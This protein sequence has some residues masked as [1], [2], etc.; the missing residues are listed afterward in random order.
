MIRFRPPSR[1]VSARLPA[2]G[3]PLSA[4]VPGPATLVD[5]LPGELL[6]QVALYERGAPSRP[7]HILEAQPSE[8][9]VYR[10]GDAGQRLA[11][12]A[13]EPAD[14]PPG[15]LLR[16]GLPERLDQ[17]AQTSLVIMLG[18]GPE[19]PGPERRTCLSIASEVLRVGLE[20]SAPT[21][22]PGQH[23]DYMARDY[24]SFQRLIL[25]R[26]THSAPQWGERH[27]ADMGV[28][29]AEVLAY[30][31]DYLSYYQDAVATE[32]YLETARRRTSVRRHVRLL[33][34]PMHEGC[35]ARV[36]VQVTVNASPVE[37]PRGTPLL[38]SAD[39]T[40]ERVPTSAYQ[41]SATRWQH[42]FETMHDALLHEAHN[43]MA[44]YTWGAERY[45]LEPGSLQAALWGHLPLL[46]AG[47]VLVFEQVGALSDSPEQNIS[48]LN[49][50]AVRLSA[51]ALLDT[52]QAQHEPITRIRWDAADA[53]PGACL[54][55]GATAGGQVC[56][57][58]W[59]VRGNLVLADA[60]STLADEPLPAVPATGRFRP[61]LRQRQIVYATPYDHAA[62]C[63]VPA[64]HILLQDP[65][66]ALPAIRLI[67]EFP[68]EGARWQPQRDLGGCGRFE[69]VFVAE[70]ESDGSCQLR[71]GNG[72]QGRLPTST[73]RL[74]ATYRVDHGTEDSIGPDTLTRI[75]SDDG[76]IEAVR[77]LLPARGALAPE[78]LSQVRLCAPAIFAH[79]HS[80]VS[81]SDYAALVE[82]HPEV[83]RA[84]VRQG[85]SGARPLLRIWVDRAGRTPLDPPFQRELRAFLA[86]YRLLGQDI[87]IEPPVPVS[88]ELGLVVR[89]R[90]SVSRQ[91]TQLALRHAFGSARLPGGQTGFFHPD[92][93]SFGQPVYLSQIVERAL[94]VSGVADVQIQTFQR[95]GL[96]PGDA[97]QTGRLDV[98][99]LEIVRLENDPRAPQHGVLT[100]T[101]AGGL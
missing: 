94:R 29:L 93:F 41:P 27:A 69:R 10:L 62:A 100:L 44:I 77:N 79:Q 61:L 60:G 25:E 36:W 2:P 85:W 71:F 74:R 26:M 9:L 47:D 1:V 7:A 35:N 64:T 39:P 34:Y 37:L 42:T 67:E 5:L 43:R 33:D 22:E 59:V 53:L 6:V 96:P 99:E 98:G 66:Q 31:A 73:T 54:V 80:A 58:L 63:R 45:L 18:G 87:V 92:N 30:S 51:D 70:S 68:E 3:L 14:D 82:Q 84:V 95:W 50:Y 101:L 13:V 56:Q 8:V 23:I 21:P 12:L 28:M 78:P 97:L 17:S 52:D 20:A 81:A 32:A 15:L 76:R 88:L 57:D 49:R 55:S 86:P 4:C 65:Q 48:Q 91:A 46:R 83:V 72:Q 16:I 40:S 19:L 75:V 11:V 90:A 38:A 24:A 89:V